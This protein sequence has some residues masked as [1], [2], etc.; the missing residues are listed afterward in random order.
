MFQANTGASLKNLE[1]QVGQ[2]ALNMQNK[3]K[4]AFPSDTQNNPK[5]CMAIQL[6]S[7]KEVSSSSRKEKKEKTDEEKEATGREEEKNMSEKTI[8]AEKQKL[9]EQPEN[10]CGLK[11]KEQVQAYT[12]A[13]PFAQRFQKAR[14]EERFSKFLKIFKKIEINIPFVEAINQMSNYEKF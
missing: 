6:R 2:L 7:G 10:S 5:D 9:T 3:N 1:T 13:V 4:G 12:P 11:Q 14:R 8:D